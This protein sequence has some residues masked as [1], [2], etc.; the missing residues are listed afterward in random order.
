MEHPAV[1]TVHPLPYTVRLTRSRSKYP[2]DVASVDRITSFIKIGFHDS[3][4]PGGSVLVT[5]NNNHPIGQ[6]HL[7]IALHGGR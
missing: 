5:R 2:Y 4:A 3:G 1:L 6:L 7:P